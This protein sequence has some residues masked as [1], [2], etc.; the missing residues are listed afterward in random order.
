MC[1]IRVESDHSRLTRL[2]FDGC[3][4]SSVSVCVHPG[5]LALLDE[6]R[7]GAVVRLGAAR[8]GAN[9][10]LPGGR[11]EMVTCIS[12]SQIPTRRWLA[13]HRDEVFTSSWLS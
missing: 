2:F 3:G 12:G 11:W 5:R 1:Y 4:I 9:A 13:S 8:P 7:A 10:T 6:E